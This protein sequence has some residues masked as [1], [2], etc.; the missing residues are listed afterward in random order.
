MQLCKS[1]F[2][3]QNVMFIIRSFLF[4]LSFWLSF[5]KFNYQM[6]SGLYL[7]YKTFQIFA[8]GG[9]IPGYGFAGDAI[10]CVNELIPK[11]VNTI[12]CSF[13]FSNPW[14]APLRASKIINNIIINKVDPVSGYYMPI[15]ETNMWNTPLYTD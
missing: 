12:S 3:V 4:L 15:E 14:W 5:S 2:Q 8:C 7:G 10:D 6:A 13:L 1:I 9:L 11:L